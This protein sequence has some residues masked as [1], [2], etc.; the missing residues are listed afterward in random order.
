MTDHDIHLVSPLEYQVFQRENREAGTIIVSGRALDQCKTLKIGIKGQ[1]YDKSVYDAWSEIPVSHLS[2]IFFSRVKTPA[3]GWYKITLQA[4]GNGGKKISETF[5]DHVGMGEVFVG[6]GQSNSTNSGELKT[7]QKSGMV[8]AFDG[9]TWQSGNDPFPGVQDGS[10]GGSYYPAFGDAIYEKYG[11]PVGIASTG[12]GGTSVNQWQPGDAL[13]N[14]MMARIHQLGKGGFRAVLWHQGENDCHVNFPDYYEKMISVIRSSTKK[15]GWE[16]PWFVAQ[17]TYHNTEK[18]SDP[19]IR[20]AQKRLWN[21][22]I[23]LPGPDTDALVGMDRDLG[24]LGIHFSPQGLKKHGM[25]W[26][27]KVS[28]YL[29]SMI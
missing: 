12:F 9:V 13:H 5:V 15:A 7:T 8:A 22:G 3:G 2:G 28:C 25:M 16:F 24:G 6:A 20:A 18:L 23:A 1:I 26:A 17:A 19:V 10:A 14:G 27:E 29:D 11:V 21:D 4:I